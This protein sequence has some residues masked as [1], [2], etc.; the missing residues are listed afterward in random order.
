MNNSV[1]TLRPIDIKKVW[2]KEERDFTPWL[3]EKGLSLLLAQLGIDEIKEINREVHCGDKSK[4][5]ADIVVKYLADEDEKTMVIENQYNACDAN[6]LGRLLMYSADKKASMVIWIT[7]DEKQ[8]YVRTIDWLNENCSSNVRF[9]LVR[10]SLVVIGD[11]VP[12]PIFNVVAQPKDGG[13]EVEKE[14]DRS[15]SQELCFTFWQS[16]LDDKTFIDTLRKSGMRQRKASVDRG[17]DYAVGSS[18]VCLCASVTTK[19][20]YIKVNFTMKNGSAAGN[21]LMQDVVR[22]RMEEYLGYKSETGQSGTTKYTTINFRRADVDIA[23]GEEQQ[24]TARRWFGEMLPRMKSF[25]ESE[26]II[27]KG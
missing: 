24:M 15:D 22:K 9:Y 25:L 14:K 6:H 5:E 8:E 19:E 1:G 13:S 3:A 2:P 12:A 27:K 23:K 4:S 21:L 11:S 7:E 26:N 18:D 20:R 16:C 17:H 10:I